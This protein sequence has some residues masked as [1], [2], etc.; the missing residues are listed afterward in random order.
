MKARY[1]L[2]MK[3]LNGDPNHTSLSLEPNV[4]GES[5]SPATALRY[6]FFN[7][8]QKYV[9]KMMAEES[10]AKFIKWEEYVKY[11]EGLRKREEEGLKSATGN[12]SN[13]NGIL[14][15]FR[16]MLFK[17]EQ[18]GSPGAQQRGRRMSMQAHR[19]GAA[20]GIA[21]ETVSN[22]GGHLP[23]SKSYQGPGRA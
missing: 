19:S 16:R 5:Y 15:A 17:T 18:P 2:A 22:S 20:K 4:N 9:F 10:V 12:A 14:E 11:M 13:P 3:F 21:P 1:D 7:V 23:Q 8:L 6:D